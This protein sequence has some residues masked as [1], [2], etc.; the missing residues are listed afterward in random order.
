MTKNHPDGSSADL[1]IDQQG[2]TV[3]RAPSNKLIIPSEVISGKH[4]EFKWKDGQ[5]YIKDVGSTL[6]TFYRVTKEKIRLGDI[7]E[8][9]SVEL[10]VRKIHIANKVS[11]AESS[12]QKEAIPVD[13]LLNDTSGDEPYNY[14]EIDLFKDDHLFRSCTVI[15]NGTIGRKSTSSISVPLDDHMSGKHCQIYF[16]N[17]HF[18]IEDAPSMNG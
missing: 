2:A 10:A 11:E 14:I 1:V 4:C 12:V 13:V 8:L 7:F 17:G 5:C 9:G 16:E 3:G 6:G 18:W 15:E